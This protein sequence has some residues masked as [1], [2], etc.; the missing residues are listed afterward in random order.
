MDSITSLFLAEFLHCSY[1]DYNC[2]NSSGA[3]CATLAEEPV[4]DNCCRL[5]VKSNGNHFNTK[6]YR[7]NEVQTIMEPCSYK[8]DR[9]KECV[10]THLPMVEDGKF[11]KA[12][13][14]VVMRT[15]QMPFFTANLAW[16]A[17]IILL[18]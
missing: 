4:I 11:Y 2:Y 13:I 12:E 16:L 5:S 10:V 18:D 15:A 7:L 14:Q 8:Y 17:L 9:M 3:S 6:R 1:D